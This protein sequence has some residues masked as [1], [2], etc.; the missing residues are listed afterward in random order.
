MSSVASSS[1]EI[2]AANDG[3]FSFETVK[4]LA[5]LD[6]HRLYGRRRAV[7]VFGGRL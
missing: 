3:E 4:N 7:V 5:N 6:Q 2:R 1:Q